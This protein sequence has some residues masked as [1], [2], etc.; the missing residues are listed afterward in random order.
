MQVWLQ[1]DPRTEILPGMSPYCS[2]NNNPI[3][4]ND[5]NGDI[6]PLVVL[7]LAAL[8][9]TINLY[10]NRHNIENFQ[11]GLVAFGIGAAAGTAAAFTGGA[12]AGAFAST[13]TVGTTIASAA[14][15]GAAGLGTESLIQSTGNALYFGD[16]SVGEALAQGAVDGIKGA[17]VGGVTGGA[18][19]GLGALANSLPSHLWVDA[20]SSTTIGL[21]G[22]ATGSSIVGG[23]VHVYAGASDKLVG[24]ANAASK[25]GST[26]FR[27]VSK[28]E[29]DD[30]AINGFRN[31][32]GAY[33]T[34]KLF[35]PTA[36]EAMQFGRNN[37]QFDKLSNTIMEVR[38]PSSVMNSAHRFGADGMNAISI[39][40]DKLHLLNGK[41]LNYSPF[42]PQ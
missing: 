38:A 4:Y 13:T 28:A 34:G 20:G 32:P 7:G 5:P 27:A 19:A 21:A 25:G 41:P 22:E 1:V 6:A 17:I 36:E 9:G 39:P 3:L 24:A 37:F 12:A 10:A 16:A 31:K 14:A 33:E 42:I 30:I 18:L 11:D 15:A 29:L 2:M 8:G 40:A 23:T 26:I 35:A